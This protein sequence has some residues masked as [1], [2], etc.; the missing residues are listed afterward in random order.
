MPVFISGSRWEPDLFYDI[1]K[2]IMSILL[3]IFGISIGSFINAAVFR[4]R[5]SESIVFDRS[6]CPKCGHILSW[7]E[8][9][10]LFS[11]LIQLGR[12]RACNQ[13]ISWQYPLVELVAGLIFMFIYYQF[14]A[15]NS[16][17][18]NFQ[19]W[20]F[21]LIFSALLFIFIF[22]FKYYIIPNK[23]L[24]PLI[25][26]VLLYNLFAFSLAENLDRLL[27]I[28]PAAG[29]F[30]ILYLISRGTWIGFGDVKFGIFMGLFL[31]WPAVLA[32]LF[33]SYLLGALIGGLLMFLGGKTL[34][35]QV[36][37]GPFLIA[38]TFIAFFYG[39]QMIKWYLTLLS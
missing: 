34:K 37:F 28:A 39:E 14:P 3:F 36:P 19:L 7:Y 1:L 17:Y 24:Y 38:G 8:L 25:A 33:L 13:K 12:C 18:A 9:I 4:L 6:R 31:G 27:A 16:Q 29:F 5:E 20:Y 30:L 10:P 23:V 15:L 2:R 11:F 32:A 35:S 21:F 22:D 26:I